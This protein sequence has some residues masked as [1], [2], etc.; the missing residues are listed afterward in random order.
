MCVSVQGTEDEKNWI[1]EKVQN[2][3][4]FQKIR[5]IKIVCPFSL[6]IQN[7]SLFFLKLSKLKLRLCEHPMWPNIVSDRTVNKR[8]VKFIVMSSG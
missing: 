5:I 3:P 4:D 1:L 2:D 6:R 8:Q 7:R